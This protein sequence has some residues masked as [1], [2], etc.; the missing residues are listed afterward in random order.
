MP[1]RKGLKRG[2]TYGRIKMTTDREEDYLEAILHL[3]NEKGYARVGNIAKGLK[4]SSATVTEML[5]RL[6]SKSLVNYEKYGG[7]TLTPEGR[8]IAEEIDR[9]H[10]IIRD[11]LLI[12]GVSDKAADEDACLI[13]HDLHMETLMKLEKFIEFIHLFPGD[14][15]WLQKFQDF[16]ETGSIDLDGCEFIGEGRDKER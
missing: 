3:V 14:P 8:K 9:R 2:D 10:V 13:E 5:G 11:F 1:V 4:C 15:C 7:V 6:S 16:Q 12:L